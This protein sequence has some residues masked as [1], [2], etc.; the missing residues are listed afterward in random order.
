M[1]FNLSSLRKQVQID[2]LDDEEFDADVIDDFINYTLMDIWNTY[3]LPFQEKIFSGTILAGSTMFK[4]PK[5]LALL[6]STTLAGVPH[7]HDH[8]MVW[9]DFIQSNSDAQNQEPGAPVRWTLYAGNVLLDRPTDVDY[10]MIMYYIKK[11]DML[12]QDTDVPELPSEFAELIV[13]GAYLRVLKR[14]EDFDLAQYVESEYNTQIGN[15]VNRYG[16]REASG[17]IKMKNKQI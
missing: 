6:Q 13:L 17:P 9:R 3:E 7:F 16:F 12:T 14:N 1:D 8:K 4:L 5:D 2:K 15:L 11:P 10:N